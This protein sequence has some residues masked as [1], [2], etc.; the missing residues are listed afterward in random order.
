MINEEKNGMLIQLHYL[1]KLSNPVAA[2]YILPQPVQN[3]G[4]YKGQSA[5]HSNRAKS[6][7]V[8]CF[9]ACKAGRFLSAS[10]HQFRA[11]GYQML[12]YH[13][14]NKPGWSWANL[15]TRPVQ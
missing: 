5:L 8:Q 6:V 11:R 13:S 15:Y 14:D 3:N 2:I 12:S 9:D 10:L 7:P 4:F 1:G